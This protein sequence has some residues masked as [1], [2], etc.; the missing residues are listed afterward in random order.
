MSTKNVNK[1][2]TKPKATQKRTQHNAKKLIYIQTFA[3][4]ITYV[5]MSCKN[6]REFFFIQIVPFC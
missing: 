1:N 4:I 2:E 3:L 5:Q 6:V